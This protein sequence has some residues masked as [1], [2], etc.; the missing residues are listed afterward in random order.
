MLA[1]YRPRIFIIEAGNS[2][3]LLGQYLNSKGISVNQVTMAPNEDVSLPPFSEALK[4][5]DD[6]NKK[7]MATEIVDD[8]ALNASITEDDVDIEDEESRDLLG[9]MEIAA[10]IMITGGDSREDDRMTRAD[11][12]MIRNAILLAAKTVFNAGREQ[13][14]TEDV[15]NALRNLPELTEKRQERAIDMAD[16]MS[17]FCDGLPGH[18]FNRPGT[19]WPDVDVTITDMAILARE[20]YE[21]QLTVAY[22]G[23][24]NHIHDLVEKHQNTD[25]PTI[26]ITD[27]GHIITT[28]PLLAPYVI[29]IVKMWRKLGAWFWIATQNLEDFPDASKK[30]LNMLEWWMCLVMPKEEVEQIAR[31]KDLSE[32]EKTMLLAARK[33][34]KQYT[35]GVVLTDELSMLFR[36]VPPP[37]ALAL[38][39]TEKDEKARRHELMRKYHCTE[40]EAVEHVAREISE[41]R[42]ALV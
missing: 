42:E 8:D 19:R 18:F 12:L 22:I 4:L 3:G 34:P 5:L 6:Y 33:S 9:E 14:L 31:F 37:L 29:K 41:N 10:R 20:G 28:N 25:R 32:E 7:G 13:V 36:N 26:V 15:A 16:S 1:I 24:M 2:F 21:D 17:L 40:L 38:A 35:E 30:M 27:E 39:M 23:L 11:R